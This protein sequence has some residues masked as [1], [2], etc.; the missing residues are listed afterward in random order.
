MSCAFLFAMCKSTSIRYFG[1]DKMMIMDQS[2]LQLLGKLDEDAPAEIPIG[3]TRLDD[4]SIPISSTKGI[5]LL[6][7]ADG[8]SVKTDNSCTPFNES[9]IYRHGWL[10]VMSSTFAI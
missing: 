10:S 6:I 1:S 4:R 8:A 9:Y 7:H 5:L 2:V 3:I